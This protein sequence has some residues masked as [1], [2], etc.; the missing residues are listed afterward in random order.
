[1]AFAVRFWPANSEDISM[2]KNSVY[3]I[4]SPCTESWNEMSGNERVRFC[5]HCAKDVN[6]I[7][8]M[9]ERKA[10]KLVR[11]SAGSL[12]I[13]YR[14]D[15][16]TK[17]PIFAP[18][19]VQIAGRAGIAAGV[20]GSSMALSAPVIA[21]GDVI[22]V[23]AIRSEQSITPRTNPTKI[24][25]Y[26]TDPE[27]AVVPFALVSITNKETGEYRVANVSP[28]GLYEFVDLPA[29][30]YSLK[31]EAG[32]FQTIEM[33][34]V[35]LGEN[36]EIRRNARLEIPQLDVVVQ[37]GG[38]DKV[39]WVVLGGAISVT[40]TFVRNDLVEAVYNN[41][42]DEVKVRVA[43]RARVNSKDKMRDGISPL[44]A[45]VET[46]SAPIAQFLLDHGAKINARDKLKRTPLM[47]L[48]NEASPELIQLMI[49]Y[50]A[51]IDL[52]DKKG[53]TVLHHFA[54]NEGG[55]DLLRLLV[56]YG[57]NV[58]ALDKE[59]KTPLML[60][61]ENENSEAVTALLENG[62]DINAETRDGKTALSMADSEGIRSVM[63][64]YGARANK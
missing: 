6:N 57:A 3:E 29:G 53:N 2:S 21:Q 35:T 42:L 16:A 32:G 22:S 20:L 36:D 23:Q 30:K 4:K 43:M 38:E 9:T 1:L 61:A 37:V 46:G 17:S 60:A 26:V 14:V 13:R 55:A 19:I 5:S 28:E 52:I 18:R 45:A 48:D 10:R 25:G 27:G 33:S 47:M 39:E 12:C 62:A 59:G 49:T 31:I 7:S 15:P 40:T 58:N 54:V 64:A 44:H 11:R 41:D 34:N 56:Q 50:G 63:Q 8:E 51:K 24:S